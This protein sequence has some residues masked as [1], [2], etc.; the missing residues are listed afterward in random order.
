MSRA[1]EPTRQNKKEFTLQ[2]PN[3]MMKTKLAPHLKTTRDGR[4]RGL[5]GEKNPEMRR[6]RTKLHSKGHDSPSLTHLTMSTRVI[7]EKREF[8]K[9][10]K[11]IL[12]LT[13]TA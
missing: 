8:N 9:H 6:K 2:K 10:M 11:A 3:E 13:N 5:P 7:Q 4:W 12:R 1:A